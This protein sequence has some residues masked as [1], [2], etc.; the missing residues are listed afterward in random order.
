MLATKLDP[1]LEPEP[2]EIAVD[3]S[4]RDAGSFSVTF[5]T[6]PVGKYRSLVQSL[7]DAQQAA[8]DAPA[9]PVQGEER[10]KAIVDRENRDQAI[11]EASLAL[12]RWGVVGF[13]GIN[14]PNGESYP[15]ALPSKTRW[16]GFEYLNL[17]NKS[18]YL[19]FKLNLL[20]RLTNLVCDFHNNELPENL[21]GFYTKNF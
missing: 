17:D 3:P 11:L 7:L 21:E 10:T 15:Q 13:S 5:Q 18:L 14:K 6:I 9:L 8:I 2:K 20:G 1:S 4:D 16:G 12:V 19:F